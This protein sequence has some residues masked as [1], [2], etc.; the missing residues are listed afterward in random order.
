MLGGMMQSIGV[1]GTVEAGEMNVSWLTFDNSNERLGIGETSPSYSL[2]IKHADNI[3]AQ[4][5]STDG[6]SEIRVKDS[7][8]YTRLLTSGNDYKIMPSDGLNEF[9]FSGDTGYFGIGKTPASP[10]DINLLTEDLEIVDAGSASAT[11][12]D[13]V[14]VEVGGNVGYIRVY[15]TK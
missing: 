5:E 4:F 13:W 10:L 7:A 14:Q 9:T 11:E 2:H 15:A 1:G 3:I 12:Q 6:V 8:K